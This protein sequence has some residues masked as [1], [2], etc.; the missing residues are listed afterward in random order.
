MHVIQETIHEAIQEV[1]EVW[2][3]IKN[4]WLIYYVLKNWVLRVNLVSY[5]VAKQIVTRDVNK[6]YHYTSSPLIENKFL[7]AK[8]LC[9]GIRS[10]DLTTGLRGC[11]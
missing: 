6:Y 10:G 1:A 5:I 2:G 3:I 7:W 11:L 9:H 8:Q 4:A